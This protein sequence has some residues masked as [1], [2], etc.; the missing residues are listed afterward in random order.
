MRAVLDANVLAPGFLSRTSASARLIDLW[1]RQ[2]SALVVSA[3]LL[4]ELARTYVDPSVQRRITPERSAR[5]RGFLR[6]LK[7]LGPS[8]G[9]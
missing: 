8:R 3:H 9:D 7:E 2:V 1:R 6:P 5:G 4:D